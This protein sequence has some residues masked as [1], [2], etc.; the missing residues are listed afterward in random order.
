M[1]A[2]DDASSTIVWISWRDAF[3]ALK[4]AVAAY[5][6]EALA[7][8]LLVRWVG[9]GK[10]PWDCELWEGPNAEWIAGGEEFN[11]QLKFR[12]LAVASPAWR[13]GDP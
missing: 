12:R 9:N 7:E 5:G 4:L 1:A 10:I 13:K 11:S 8:E 6:S 2:A 3:N